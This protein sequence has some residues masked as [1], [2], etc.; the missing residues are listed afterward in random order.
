MRRGG[1]LD[2]G[3]RSEANAGSAGA[4]AA[5]ARCHGLTGFC[6]YFF[7]GVADKPRRAKQREF[8]RAE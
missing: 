1:E 4:A 7:F 8:Y 6:G 3:R 5:M 2:E